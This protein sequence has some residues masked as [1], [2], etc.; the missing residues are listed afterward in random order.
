M[1]NIIFKS[2]LFEESKK[3]VVEK[4]VKA[5]LEEDYMSAIHLLVPQ[6]ESAI[7]AL[8]ELMGGGES[9]I[10]LTALHSARSPRGV[11]VA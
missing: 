2:P 3:K 8:V 7:R 1:T 4:G 6:A 9:K 5:F 11:D 10:D